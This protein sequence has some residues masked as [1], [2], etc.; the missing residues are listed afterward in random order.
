MWTER[1]VKRLKHL[2]DAGHTASEIA[3]KLG[4]TRNA[5]IGKTH[6]E[7]FKFSLS[8]K[9]NNHGYCEKIAALC[10][11]EPRLTANEISAR[12]GCSLSYVYRLSTAISLPMDKKHYDL[13]AR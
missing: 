13:G 6:R 8:G 5:V 11:R 9:Y 4:V 3:V 7:G 12:I 10:E 1:K 2:L